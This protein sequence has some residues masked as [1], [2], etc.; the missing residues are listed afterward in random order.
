VGIFAAGVQQVNESIG[1]TVGTIWAPANT[2]TTTYGPLGS[3]TT[4]AVISGL[5]IQNTG[6]ATMFIGTGTAIAGTGLPVNPGAQIL[7]TGY[8]AT[9]GQTPGTLL[10]I[11]T[12][13]TTSSLAGL[14]SVTSVI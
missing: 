13:G 14:P 3:V 1:S 4:G 5:V 8:A 7:Y 2:S 12:S 10:G 9:G 6:T 11:T